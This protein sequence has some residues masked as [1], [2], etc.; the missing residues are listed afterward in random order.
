M[1]NLREIASR[2][3]VLRGSRLGI[4]LA[5]VAFGI[6]VADIISTEILIRVCHGTEANLIMWLVMWLCNGNVAWW[7]PKTIV[8]VLV[9]CYLSNTTRFNLVTVTML[10]IGTLPVLINIVQ[11]LMYLDG[12]IGN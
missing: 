3:P 11:Y 10:K 9:F 6:Q 4:T 1:I 7:L 2:M 8:G 5:F 12:I